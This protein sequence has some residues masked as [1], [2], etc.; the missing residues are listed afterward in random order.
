MEFGLSMF[1]VPNVKGIQAGER[2]QDIDYALRRYVIETP[3]GRKAMLNGSGQFWIHQAP[4]ED[5]WASDQ[6]IEVRTLVGHFDVIDAR[7]KTDDGHY[8]R[9]LSRFFESVGY[10]DLTAD[11]ASIFDKALDRVCVFD[12]KV[13]GLGR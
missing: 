4:I 9:Y 2:S 5:V 6:F 10:E 1:C 11:E 3:E 7:G 13:P 12:P 8:W